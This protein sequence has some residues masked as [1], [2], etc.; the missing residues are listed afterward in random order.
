[1]LSVETATVLQTPLADTTVVKE[2]RTSNMAARGRVVTVRPSA[3]GLP[4]MG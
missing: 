2:L 3:E 4:M 1:M